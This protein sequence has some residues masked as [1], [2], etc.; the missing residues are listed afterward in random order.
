MLT[1]QSGDRYVDFFQNDDA[2][3]KLRKQGLQR[4][5]KF[6]FGYRD[7]RD[8][9][10]GWMRDELKTIKRPENKLSSASHEKIPPRA[11]IG[12]LEV[13]DLETPESE[14]DDRDEIDMRLNDHITPEEEQQI[15]AMLCNRYGKESGRRYLLVRSLT[16]PEK[17]IEA[18]TTTERKHTESNTPRKDVECLKIEIKHKED[19]I[20]PL[21]SEDVRKK[22]ET[23]VDIIPTCTTERM[24]EPKRWKD[25]LRN[26][27]KTSQKPLHVS[28]KADSEFTK[29]VSERWGYAPCH[30]NL[31]QCDCDLIKEKCSAPKVTKKCDMANYLVDETNNYLITC[32]ENLRDK[33]YNDRRVTVLQQHATKFAS[34]DTRE[35]A[36]LKSAHHQVQNEL[37]TCLMKVMPPQGQEVHQTGVAHVKQMTKVISERKMI[38][39]H[40]WR[41]WRYAHTKMEHKE[42]SDELDSFDSDILSSST[43]D[44]G[45]SE[46]N[47]NYSKSLH[48]SRIPYFKE[49]FQLANTLFDKIDAKMEKIIS[50]NRDAKKMGMKKLHSCLLQ[51]KIRILRDD[52][53]LFDQICKQF[54]SDYFYIKRLTPFTE[55]KKRKRARAN[56]KKVELGRKQNQRKLIEGLQ[57]GK[58]YRRPKRSF[59]YTEE[60]NYRGFSQRRQKILQKR[61]TE[62]F[63]KCNLVGKDVT[64]RRLSK[65]VFHNDYRFIRRLF[66]DQLDRNKES[67]WD[68]GM[69][70]RFEEYL[71]AFREEKN[72]AEQ[73]KEEDED[74][75]EDKSELSVS[76]CSIILMT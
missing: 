62:K 61:G 22:M 70:A 25:A 11:S 29:S 14:N 52:N 64:G 23:L 54:N 72:I 51:E 33:K 39:D 30:C 55:R 41:T 17:K 4:K 71:V 68:P 60:E 74:K 13:N 53:I 3:E 35:S 24:E 47:I 16:A 67:L 10:S 6:G 1:T 40:E 45:C 58:Q 44:D 65:K 46:C 5:A 32:R 8:D 76:Y 36:Y 66:D 48:P 43:S 75:D 27:F 73:Y 2:S 34:R 12:S 50:K 26:P 57:L 69:K 63:R 59:L 28:I 15:Y 18:W 7:V 19:E 20:C 56:E 42:N 21:I 31:Y 9:L 49:T 38:D 37:M